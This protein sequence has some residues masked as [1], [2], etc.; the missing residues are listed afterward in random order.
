MISIIEAI[1]KLNFDYNNNIAKEMWRDKIQEAKKNFNIWFDLENN[2][3]CKDNSQRDIIIPQ[4]E[5]EHANCKFRC[6]LWCAGGDWEVPLYYFKCQLLDGYAFNVNKYQCPFFIFIPGKTEG[7]YHLIKAKKEGWCVPDNNDYKKGIDPE[8][9]KTD[10]WKAL[11]EYL[12]K[13]VDLE[14]EK[15]RQEQAEREVQSEEKQPDSEPS[16]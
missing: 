13:L 12:K 9:S 2:D 6:Q 1:E 14:I 4:D 15:V 5:W 3:L 10:C 11:Q 16:K 7:N 8:K